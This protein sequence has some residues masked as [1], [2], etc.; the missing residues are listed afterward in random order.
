ANVLLSADGTP[1]IADFGLA[2]FLGDA[3]ALT[4]TGDLL[5]TPGYMAPEQAAGK[6]AGAGPA[7]DVWALG[8]ILYECL[9]GQQAFGASTWQD[10]LRQVLEEEPVAPRRLRGDVPRE[11]EAV[12][13][14]CLSKAPADRYA[15]AQDLADDLDRWLAG[16]PVRARSPSLWWRTDRW[17]RRLPEIGALGLA[18]LFFGTVIFVVLAASWLLAATALMIA[19][20][21]Y[22][23]TRAGPRAAAVGAV[24]GALALLGLPVVLRLERLGDIPNG[25]IPLVVAS[26]ALLTPLAAAW[27]RSHWLSKVIL[28]AAL[29]GLVLLTAGRTDAVVALSYVAASVFA[30][31]GYTRA[32]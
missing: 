32:V 19:L 25:V 5:G 1:K 17:V 22:S 28:P 20:A 24:G 13:L 31:W 6:A 18:A 2:R 11:V 12:C 3:D 29:A 23:A 21:G 4:Q 14:K 9:T 15:T 16:E 10:A 8:A 26:P 27:W 30:L 7:A